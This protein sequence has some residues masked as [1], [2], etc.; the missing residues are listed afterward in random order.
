LDVLLKEIVS[1]WTKEKEDFY[2][3]NSA[4]FLAF[5]LACSKLTPSHYFW[6]VANLGRRKRRKMKEKLRTRSKVMNKNKN[7]ERK[8]KDNEL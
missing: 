3:C 1:V 2:F 4:L 5:W 7:K 6:Q 8:S